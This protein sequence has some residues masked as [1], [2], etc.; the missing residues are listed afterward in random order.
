MI[1]P[2]SRQH[3]SDVARLHRASLTGLLA[4]L[5]L[6]AI[7]AFYAAC[8][9]SR[10]STA[11]VAVEGTVVRGFVLGSAE[12]HRLRAATMRSKPIA[13]LWGIATGV[14]KKP[15]ALISLLRSFGGPEEGSYDR[16]SPELLYLAVANES[17]GSGVGAQ[18][19]TA[20]SEAMAAAGATAYELSVDEDNQSAITFYERLGFSLCGQYKEFGVWHRRYRR[21]TPLH[22]R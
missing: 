14:A 12:S 13:T 7:S 15:S 8:T 16:D 17:R 9:E 6:P 20:F 10:L 11:F 2:M 3:V 5:G 18:L 1:V 21:E 22:Q 4:D 19:V